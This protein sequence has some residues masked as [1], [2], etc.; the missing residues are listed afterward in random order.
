MTTTELLTLHDKVCGEAKAIMSAKNHDY[1]AGSGDPF[2]NFRASSALG[3]PPVQGILL[4][5]MDKLKRI[6]CFAERGELRV[7]GE[8]VNDAFRDV[9]NYMVLCRGLCEEAAPEQVA[10]VAVVDTATP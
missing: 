7:A 8:G 5:V 3:V 10:V 4:R 6:Q 1:T 9:I 2:A